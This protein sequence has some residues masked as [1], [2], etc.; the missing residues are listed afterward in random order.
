M[1]VLVVSQD[2]DD[3]RAIGPHPWRAE[4]ILIV[5]D[6]VIIPLYRYTRLGLTKSY[7]KRTFS[8]GSGDERL[9]K[10]DIVK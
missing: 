9:E 5:Q 7:V 4:D 10:W 6:A 8:L 1:Q 2:E 3:I